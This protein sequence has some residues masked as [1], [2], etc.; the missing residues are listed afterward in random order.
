MAIPTNFST[1]TL[2]KGIWAMPKIKLTQAAVER[3]NPP[4][5]GR[6]EY[7]D[8]VLPGFGLRVSAEGRKTWQ[9]L[10][11]AQGRSVRETLGTLA[12]VP[13][14]EDARVLA[15]AS[16]LK[17]RQGLDPVADRRAAKRNTLN[18]TLDR[19]L[20]DAKKRMASN[21]YAET[22]RALAAD[23]RPALGSKPI[24]EVSR[25]EIREALGAVMARGSPSHAN[26]VL[27]YL[28][29]ALGWAVR[30]DIIPANPAEGIKKPAPAGERDRALSDDEIRAFW[31]AADELRGAFGPFFQF[32]LLTGQRR[33]ETTKATWAEFDEALWTIPSEHTKNKREHLVPLAPQARALLDALPRYPGTIDAGKDD[34]PDDAFR[35]TREEAGAEL[36]FTATGNLLAGFEGAMFRLFKIMHKITGK[37][38]EHFTPHDLRRTATTGM[39]RLG[40]APHVVDKILNHRGGTISGTAGIYNRF[41]YLDERRMALE[42]WGRHIE[43]LIKP[44]AGKVI[45]LRRGLKR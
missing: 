29:A 27:A 4:A 37:P 2:P 3:L 24:A 13:K 26:H 19:Y 32:L 10:Y 35:I 33:G 9:V 5:A 41:E 17:A 14:V 7:W 39:A 1:H 34:R 44:S 21:Y 12:V 23:V 8:S 28:R 30:E 16:I 11:R 43:L 22:V 42:E 40:V 20:I 36:V 38:P 31:L 6:V 18:A 45:A 15:R 25:R